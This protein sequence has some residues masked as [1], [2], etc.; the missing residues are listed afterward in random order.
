VKKLNEDLRLTDEFWNRAFE[1]DLYMCCIDA[2]AERAYTFDQLREM[3]DSLW[4]RLISKTQKAAV[5]VAETRGSVSIG[6]LGAAIAEARRESGVQPA[7][8]Y[9]SYDDPYKQAAAFATGLDLENNIMNG[10]EYV[11]A[12]D[13]GLLI[14]V[15]GSIVQGM[16]TGDDYYNEKWYQYLRFKAVKSFSDGGMDRLQEY[17]DELT[18]SYKRAPVLSAYLPGPRYRLPLDIDTDERPPNYRPD[19][20]YDERRVEAILGTTW[21][22]AGQGESLSDYYARMYAKAV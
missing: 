18:E 15:A 17:S 13:E 12:R 20:D 7:D 1:A 3:W 21:D 11:S 16:K 8:P 9:S 2:D 19:H 4:D 10:N 5:I 22:P 6:E 14:K